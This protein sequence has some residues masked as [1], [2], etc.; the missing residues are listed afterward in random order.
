MQDS[1]PSKCIAIGQRTSCSAVIF[2]SRYIFLGHLK[3]G[4]MGEV[5]RTEEGEIWGKTWIF[6]KTRFPLFSKYI[7][8]IYETDSSEWLTEDIYWRHRPPEGKLQRR[9]WKDF[10]LNFDL[11][12]NIVLLVFQKKIP[13]MIL[14]LICMAYNIFQLHI[15]GQIGTDCCHPSKTFLAIF[16]IIWIIVFFLSLHLSIMWFE[17]Q[18]Q[19]EKLISLLSSFTQH[20]TF[21]YYHFF[22]MTCPQHS[23]RHMCTSPC[24]KVK[25]T[26]SHGRMGSQD[27][28]GFESSP[29]KIKIAK[30]P[31]SLKKR[32]F[33]GLFPKPANTHLFV[34]FVNNW[35]INV[36]CK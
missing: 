29:E 1:H 28:R 14:I 7:L 6:T 9:P 11:F 21:Y 35:I 23:W 15:E 12:G 22:L 17:T 32:S 19:K 26:E 16:K 27:R 5:G 30:L 20:F 18:F 25:P 33:L 10:T 2:L 34:V 3:A 13:N 31:W 24:P 4:R 36:N 8:L